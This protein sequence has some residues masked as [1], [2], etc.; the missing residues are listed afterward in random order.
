MNKVTGFDN[1]PNH[2]II[3]NKVNNTNVNIK[4]KLN[5]YSFIKLK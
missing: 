5:K 4:T 3:G 1:K 2:K